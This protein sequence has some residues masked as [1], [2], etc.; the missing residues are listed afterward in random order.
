MIQSFL[1]SLLCLLK[2]PLHQDRHF[3]SVQQTYSPRK[4][5]LK[6]LQNAECRYIFL[7]LHTEKKEIDDYLLGL[8]EFGE[9]DSVFLA[10]N[11]SKS[12]E[13]LFDDRCDYNV[14]SF[15]LQKFHLVYTMRFVV[16][17]Y[18]IFRG[19]N[20]IPENKMQAE[21]LLDVVA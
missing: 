4:A 14:G 3:A 20:D 6:L 13:K 15:I 7:R 1:L 10:R 11:Q 9:L 8:Q 21:T 17:G 5:R 16:E 12:W 19:Y 18:L 2:F